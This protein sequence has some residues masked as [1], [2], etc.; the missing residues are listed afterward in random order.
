MFIQ[1]DRHCQDAFSWQL[2]VKNF[3]QLHRSVLSVEVKTDRNCLQKAPY[4]DMSVISASNSIS[5]KIILLALKNQK[6]FDFVFHYSDFK[7]KIRFSRVIVLKR[8][9]S[10]V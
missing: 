1:N 10:L 7:Y 2:I 3:R 9:K 8:F 5:Y 4:G 6:E